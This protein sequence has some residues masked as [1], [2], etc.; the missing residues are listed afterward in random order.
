[1]RPSYIPPALTYDSPNV[2]AAA[3]KGGGSVDLL[4]MPVTGRYG[5]CDRMTVV[6]YCVA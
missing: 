5:V 2:G 3:R 4:L 1:M 6:E